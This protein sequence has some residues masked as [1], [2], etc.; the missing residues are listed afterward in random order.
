MIIHTNKT[1]NLGDLKLK[2]QH[3]HLMNLARKIRQGEESYVS[4]EMAMMVLGIGLFYAL[5]LL[6]AKDTLLFGGSSW[7]QIDFFFSFCIVI[8]LFVGARQKESPHVQ[9][10]P[11][12]IAFE[13]LS[14]KATFALI[15]TVGEIGRKIDSKYK[16]SLTQTDKVLFRDREAF[17]LRQLKGKHC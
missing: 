5:L 13:N 10:Q 14:I 8:F 1:E 7:N 2:V 3:E 4:K 9:L 6:L 17:F 12:R 15:G 11:N 16:L